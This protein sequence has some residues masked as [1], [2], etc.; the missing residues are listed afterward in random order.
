MKEKI[1]DCQTC[2]PADGEI[3]EPIEMGPDGKPL[4]P[5][6]EFERYK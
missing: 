3:Y 6:G 2:T 1:H 4:N 5:A